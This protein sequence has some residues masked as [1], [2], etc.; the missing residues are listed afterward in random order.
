MLARATSTGSGTHK[1]TLLGRLGVHAW[2]LQYRPAGAFSLLLKGC[3]GS[4]ESATAAP[5]LAVGGPNGLY[6][7]DSATSVAPIFCTQG[8]MSQS[9]GARPLPLSWPEPVLA[10]WHSHHSS[11]VSLSW[12]WSS[13]V[14]HSVVCTAISKLG[15][16][17][18][19][20]VPRPGPCSGGYAR[21]HSSEAWP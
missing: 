13:L 6:A 11:D 2:P 1:E 9:E 5:F 16:R 20:K 17:P 7:G 3:C 12:P 18:P 10:S 21:V 8:A 4:V 19:V 15:Q 14:R